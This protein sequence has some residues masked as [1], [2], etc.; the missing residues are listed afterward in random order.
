MI[1]GRSAGSFDFYAPR[2]RRMIFRMESLFSFWGCTHTTYYVSYSCVLLLLA[3]SWRCFCCCWMLRSPC[4]RSDRQTDRQNGA[5]AAAALHRRDRRPNRRLHYTIAHKK[6]KKES[7]LFRSFIIIKPRLRTSIHIYILVRT[8]VH[9]YMEN[10]RRRH[11]LLIYELWH[12]G[13]EK[14]IRKAKH[15]FQRAHMH[16]RVKIDRE[17]DRQ[18]DRQTDRYWLLLNFFSWK[19]LR[20][21]KR[22]IMRHLKIY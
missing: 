12:V 17:T 1:L 10:G 9:T 18:T 13:N 19:E 2:V 20:G 4:T 5:A 8:Y 16:V 7:K 21:E 11:H 6:K 3:F 15:T 22:E 14:K